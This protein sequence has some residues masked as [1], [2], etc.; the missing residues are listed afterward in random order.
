MSI[1]RTFSGG[2]K[3]LSGGFA[4]NDAQTNNGNALGVPENLWETVG[5]SPAYADIFHQSKELNPA[6]GIDGLNTRPGAKIQY[7]HM[8]DVYEGKVDFTWVHGR[9]T[10]QM[11]ADV[12]TDNTQSP[13]EY[14]DEDFNTPQTGN[15]E[16]ATGVVTGSSIASFLLGVPDYADYRNVHETT[17][18]GWIDGFY[19][20]DSWKATEKLTVNI[21]VR[22]DVLL[23]AIYGS[24][25]Q[26]NQYEGDLNLDKGQYILSRMAPAC[27]ATVGAPCIP[28]GTLPANVIVTPFSN[29]RIYDHDWDNIGPRVG[30]A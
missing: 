7:T 2:S 29:G 4:R 9:H 13:I 16:A 19:F 1:T 15:P 3:V 20:Q 11:G 14:I 8:S 27:S 28:G 17:H 30:L 12:A 6:V 25:S 24:P 18:G 10:M 23:M 22:Y 21:G 26:G 5:F